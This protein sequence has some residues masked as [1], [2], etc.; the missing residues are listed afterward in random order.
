V[1][2]HLWR[3][4]ITSGTVKDFV[5]AASGTGVFVRSS[6][7][8]ALEKALKPHF[9][10]EKYE[11]GL[12]VHGATTDEVGKLVFAAGIPLLE[13]ANQTVSLEDAFLEVT[14]DSQE[15]KGGSK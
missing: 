6:K 11:S 4:L 2:W 10:T 9:Q 3:K 15:Y 1:K 8:G 12:K 5:D 7:L 13:L 14:A